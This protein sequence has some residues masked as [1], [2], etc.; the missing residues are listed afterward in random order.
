MTVIS[1]FPAVTS[2]EVN[3]PWVIFQGQMNGPSILRI[4][5]GTD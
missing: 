5:A 2:R 4:R 1:P 3:K